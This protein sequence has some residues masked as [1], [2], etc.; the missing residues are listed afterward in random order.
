MLK[1]ISV[2]DL[3]VGM[4]VHELGGAW[5][6]HPIWRTSF[7]IKTG[8]DLA[9]IVESG[10]HEAWIDTVRGLDVPGGMTV[11]ESDAEVERDLVST[12]TE[13][14]MPRRRPMEAEIARAA[15][16]SVTA[17]G[18]VG[19]LFQE[20]RMGKAIQVETVVPVVDQVAESVLSNPGVLTALTRL[21]SRDNYT[22]LHSVS[23]CALMVALGYQL[24][25]DR[26]ELRQTG[27]AG[28]L[29]D[30]GK[31]RID[32]DLLNKRGQLSDDEFTLLRG[33]AP[34]GHDILNRGG[35]A[36][37]VALDV[38]LHHHER[39]DG[40]GYPGGL[41]GDDISLHARM[42]AVCD[43]YD[44][45][46]SNR[47]YKDAWQPAHALRKMTEWSSG[48]FD[49]RVFHA[50]VKTVGIYPIG[51]LVR[52]KS[53]RLGVV[54]DQSEGSLLAPRVKVFYSIPA[55]RRLEPKVIDLSRPGSG[56]EILGHEDPAVWAID[57][58]TFLWSGTDAAKG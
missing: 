48:H 44:A 18:T 17:C 56:D 35:N 28:L 29:H 42:A 24:G 11:E 36:G 41:A 50:F 9:K 1:R 51:T 19:T 27:M 57:D 6:D 25:L 8:K 37:E 20:A 39:M 3:K 52:L 33:H 13:P 38:C 2:R 54:I 23:V 32:T 15:R 47:P 49:V 10:I 43:V 40:T 46:T 26:E 31:I 30:I 45:T 12:A 58:L 5:L 16:I 55:K 7:K 21:R 14:V 22:Y 4:F 53:E 34:A